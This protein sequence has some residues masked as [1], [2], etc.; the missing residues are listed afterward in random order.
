MWTSW[1]ETQDCSLCHGVTASNSPLQCIWHAGWP[2]ID[3][4]SC[5][6]PL[7]STLF[8]KKIRK[9]NGQKELAKV[10]GCYRPNLRRF[11]IVKLQ[12]VTLW[13]VTILQRNK[14]SCH[15]DFYRTLPSKT[16]PIPEVWFKSLLTCVI[17]NVKGLFGLWNVSNYV[18][19][20]DSKIEVTSVL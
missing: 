9:E 6:W 19:K 4:N 12:F 2:V 11:W 10:F 5:I 18:H 7:S 16:E 8:Q 15:A 13:P 17:H 3:L 1:D 20:D 14:S